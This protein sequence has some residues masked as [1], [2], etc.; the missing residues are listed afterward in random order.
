MENYNLIPKFF[1]FEVDYDGDVMSIDIPSIDETEEVKHDVGV[2]V[3]ELVNSDGFE[4]GE[5]TECDV[6]KE[7]G[8]LFVQG[9][10][11]TELGDD[12]DTD[13]WE[14]FELNIKF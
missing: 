1:S 3:N 13:V 12:Y 10:V 8:K 14:D 11:C 5:K 7:D 2:L 9:R 4:L 6:W